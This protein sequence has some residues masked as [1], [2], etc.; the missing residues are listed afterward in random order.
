M[1]DVELEQLL[2]A[3]KTFVEHW[4]AHDNKLSA[5]FEIFKKRIIVVKVNEDIANASGCSIDKLTRFIKVTETMFGTELLNRFL[6]AYKNGENVEVVHATKV[7]ELLAQHVL[8]EQT[9]I[10]NTSIANENELQN[11]EQALKE[12]WLNK[13]LV[14][15]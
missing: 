11:W 14:T 3:G 12:T 2:K 4:T 10:Y 13:Y 5:T 15:S 9:I 7:K 1:G 6:V 8:S